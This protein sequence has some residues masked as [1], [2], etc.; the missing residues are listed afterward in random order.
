MSGRI[1]GIVLWLVA[2]VATSAQAQTVE[3]LHTDALGS[4]VAVTDANRNVIERRE[5][6]PYGWQLTPA[7]SNGPGYTGH[8]QDAATG[9]VYMQQRYYDAQLGRFLSM[10]PVTANSGTG[11]NFNRYW[12]ADNNPYTFIDP[13]GEGAVLNLFNRNPAAHIADKDLI[14]HENDLYSSTQ[15]IN[16]R[17]VNVL[18]AH[19]DPR[20]VT[21]NRESMYRNRTTD[22]GLLAK[23]LMARRGYDPLQPLILTACNLQDTG[24]PGNL[25]MATNNTVLAGNGYVWQSSNS[26]GVSLSVSSSRFE[27]LGDRS[28]VEYAAS[29]AKTGRTFSDIRIG[30]DGTVTLKSSQ[31]VTGSRI[32][33]QVTITCTEKGGCK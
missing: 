6:E 31:Q 26:G 5:Y 23:E 30:A 33:R 25:A 2:A 12:Y 3:Y 22:A 7:V 19:G 17:Y 20:G 16:A 11:A 4:V 14:K 32:P 9:L 18:A 10:D 15:R 28:F 13:T 24:I 27:S 21:D 8:V 1:A 29:G